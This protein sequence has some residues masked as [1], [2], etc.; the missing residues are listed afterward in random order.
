MF[1]FARKEVESRYA[2]IRICACNDRDGSNAAAALF[3][4]RTILAAP[5]RSAVEIA[6][7]L[8]QCAD[9]LRSNFCRHTH[10]MVNPQ[11]SVLNSAQT[12]LAVGSEG[13]VRVRFHNDASPCR[14]DRF[15]IEPAGGYAY[16]QL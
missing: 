12:S 10:R 6:T 7:C 4:A 8:R 15:A 14:C 2:L 13:R 3:A 11:A 16:V 1:R 5:R 9:A